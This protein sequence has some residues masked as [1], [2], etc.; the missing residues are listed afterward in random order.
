[1][2][3]QDHFIVPFNGINHTIA[4]MGDLYKVYY[5]LSNADFLDD[6]D[7]LNRVKRRYRIYERQEPDEK[8]ESGCPTNNGM[9]VFTFINFVMGVVSVAANVINNINSNNNNN[10]RSC[11][12]TISQKILLN[13]SNLHFFR[14]IITITTTIMWPTL[15]LEI[16]IM[17][18]TMKTS[19]CSTHLLEEDLSNLEKGCQTRFA[20]Q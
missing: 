13:F 6:F 4:N 15:T 12:F 17:L 14:T 7:T 2:A 16:T 3:L 18:V 8:P 10:V 19:S 5:E 9:S 11:L 20:T 1:M